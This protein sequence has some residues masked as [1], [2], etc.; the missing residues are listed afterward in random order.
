MKG[1]HLSPESEFKRGCEGNTRLE[2]GST[3]IR[4][5]KQGLLRAWVKIGEPNVWRERARL[6]WENEHGRIPRGM[7]V[8]HHDRDALNDTLDNLRLLTKA[9]HLA[10]HRHEFEKR[11]AAAATIARWGKRIVQPELIP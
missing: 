4:R 2:V 9:Q 3:T 1:I 7:I 6:V 5:D 10:E 8:H 11:R